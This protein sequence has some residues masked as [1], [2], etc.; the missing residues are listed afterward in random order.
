MDRVASFWLCNYC[1]YKLIGSVGSLWRVTVAMV[2]IVVGIQY[3]TYEMVFGG[4]GDQPVEINTKKEKIR[5][6]HFHDKFNCNAI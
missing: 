3:V 2:H 6:Q 1:P 4:A 5:N